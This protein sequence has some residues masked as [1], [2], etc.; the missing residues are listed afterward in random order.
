MLLLLGAATPLRAD[1]LRDPSDPGAPVPPQRY[2][3]VREGI[4]SFRPV[5]PMP[6]GQTSQK[7]APPL[8]SGPDAKQKK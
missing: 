5:E 2:R 6:W 7:A 4:R 8:K 1:P 3:P